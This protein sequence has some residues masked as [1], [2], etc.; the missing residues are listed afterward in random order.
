MPSATIGKKMVQDAGLRN[1]CVESGVISEGS[2]T[3]VME[4]RNYNR[5]VSI[6]KIM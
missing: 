5:I 1:L 2:I 6:H 4:A 3:A